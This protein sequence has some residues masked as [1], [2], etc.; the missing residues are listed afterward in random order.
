MKKIKTD[1]L[2]AGTGV[3][4]LYCAI[5]LDSKYSITML[6]KKAANECNTYLAQGG[7]S[8]CVNKY[9]INS[10]INDTLNAGMQLNNKAAVETLV[11]ESM[12]DIQRLDRLGVPFNKHNNEF[13]YTKEGGHVKNRIVHCDDN[14]GKEVFNTLYSIVKGLPNVEILE[15]AEL[16][17]LSIEN[18]QCFG[19]Y[20]VYENEVLCIESKTTLLASGGMGGLF[21]NS[22][23]QPCLTGDGIGMAGRNN[24]DVSSMEHIQFHPTALLTDK[25]RDKRRFLIS[26]S[27]R[28]EG[29]LLYNSRGERFVDELLPRNVVSAA[30]YK[31]LD[32]TKNTCVFLDISHTDREYLKKRFPK[33]YYQCL[34]YGID[35]AK[36]RI[37]VAP[38]QH[39]LMGGISVDLLGR[40]EVKNLYATGECA[41]TGVHGGNRLASNSLLEGLVFSRRAAFDMLKAIEIFG[42]S[43]KE[44]YTLSL[45]DKV[46]SFEDALDISRKN[47]LEVL[48]IIKKVRKDL[49]NELVDC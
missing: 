36:D 17:E 35:I 46:F 40:T 41:C 24:I 39:Y 22:T 12:E 30:I 47:R 21:K 10:F 5:N 7:I 16:F 42:E 38:S 2:I 19:G 44:C 13:D 14:T 26:E 43:Y 25:G 27:L 6:S 28:G 1:V 8:V 3:A 49:K 15:N 37:P 33:I 4:G 18:R 11:R 23:N 29:A 48:K 31:E 32:K 34:E 20:C 9:D 45:Y